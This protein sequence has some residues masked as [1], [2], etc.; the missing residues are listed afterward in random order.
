MSYP[1][2]PAYPQFGDDLIGGVVRKIDHLAGMKARKAAR[3]QL[4]YN[5][6]PPDIR[7]E[8]PQTHRIPCRRK[9]ASSAPM[10]LA[11]IPRFRGWWG[12]PIELRMKTWAHHT[13]RLPSHPGHHSGRIWCRGTPTS[14]KLQMSRWGRIHH[15]RRQSRL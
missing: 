12:F 10:P 11:F 14:Q 9:A 8:R 13:H 5:Q 15:L 1:P 3:I 7:P 4:Q 6:L 2:S